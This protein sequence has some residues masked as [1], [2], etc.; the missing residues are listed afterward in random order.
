MDRRQWCHSS[1]YPHLQYFSFYHP[2]NHDTFVTMPNSKQAKIH[3]IGTI[4]LTPSLTLVHA[5]HVP[6]F[7]DNLLSASKLTK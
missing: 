5:L 2:L 7:H 4:H 6:N 3:H 1:Y